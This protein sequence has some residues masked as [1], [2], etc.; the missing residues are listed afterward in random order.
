MDKAAFLDLYDQH[1]RRG[2]ADVRTERE[3]EAHVIRHVPTDEHDC[4]IV[5]SQLTGDNADEVIRHER[6]LFLQRN[7]LVE[8]KVYGHDQ[9]ADLADRLRSAG[10]TEEE[11]EAL[12][13][14]DVDSA[15][16]LESDDATEGEVRVSELSD[17]ERVMN[18]YRGVW[19]DHAD[20][21]E[22][23]FEQHMTG[24]AT[25]VLVHTELEGAVVGAAW[26]TFRDGAQMA[27]LWAGTVIEEARQR[28]FYRRMTQKRLEI[29]RERGMRY[30]A[31]DAGPQSRPILERMGFQFITSITP[32]LFDP[33]RSTLKP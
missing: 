27:E 6:D 16:V 30:A 7:R 5:W 21:L 9:P 1:V 29:A 11:Q 8:W 13:A 15:A 4:W 20:E 26:M 32:C 10:F 28:G 31:V 24:Q 17:I 33:A 2:P 25:G 23:R 14:I 12:L 19:P 18:V 3:V 22:R